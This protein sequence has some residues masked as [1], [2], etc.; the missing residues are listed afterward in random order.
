MVGIGPE[1]GLKFDSTVE[2]KAVGSPVKLA[3]S[4][5]CWIAAAILAYNLVPSR[6][7]LVVGWLVMQTA[8]EDAGLVA[9]DCV[10]L[11]GS[12]LSGSWK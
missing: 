11:R 2:E 9:V 3:V 12:R 6:I 5:T 10:L 7:I 4:C 8:K 1:V